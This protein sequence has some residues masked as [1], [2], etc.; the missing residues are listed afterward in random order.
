M[1]PAGT[2]AGT[3]LDPEGKPPPYAVIFATW[4]GSGN[5]SASTD[6]A[7][8]FTVRV[9]AKG[10]VKLTLTGQVGKEHRPITGEL[11]EVAAGGDDVVL[12]ARTIDMDRTLRIR[13]VDP[14]GQ[15]LAGISLAVHGTMP[16]TDEFGVVE[17][18]GLPGKKIQ[19]LVFSGTRHEALLKWALPE[20]LEV[21]PAGQEVLLRF[22]EA[23][24][25]S[26]KVTLPDG[27]P[28]R[29]AVAARDA[30]G[31]FLA[32]VVTHP[33]DGAFALMIPAGQ[34]GPLTLEIRLPTNQYP[35]LRDQRIPN[36][37]PGTTGLELR[38]R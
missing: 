23:A 6:A 8:R 1:L 14:S 27:K 5:R 31:G 10:R 30:A 12:R 28:A 33:E 20:R 17:L 37:E 18:K 11:S 2:I 32:Q 13:V 25:V 36:I 7:G 24:P 29:V 15:P 21:V 16:V 9:P 22:R 3:V 38:L 19:V 4:E 34:P 35:E 26:G